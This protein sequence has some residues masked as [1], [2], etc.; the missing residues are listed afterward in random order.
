[1]Q[2]RT[3]EE[4][5]VGEGC[6]ATW[7]RALPGHHHFYIRHNQMAAGQ[8]KQGLDVPELLYALAEQACYL[9]LAVAEKNVELVPLKS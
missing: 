9:K 6:R 7:F 5:E 8:A 4:V 3:R 1:M 2:N